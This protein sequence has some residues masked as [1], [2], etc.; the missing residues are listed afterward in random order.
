M[1]ILYLGNNWLGWQILKWLA[2]QG[3]HVVGLVIHAPA[4]QKFVQ[5]ILAAASLPDDRVFC[6]SDLTCKD[7]LDQIESLQPDIGLSVLF[8]HILR[9]SF[10]QIMPLG[11]LN[12]HPGLLPYN[13]GANPNVW[14][15]VDGTPAG[16]T[17]HRIDEG[18]D[19]GDI[20][21][22]CRVPTKPTDTGQRLYRR[23]ELASIELFQKTWPI[24]R[25]GQATC[26]PQDRSLGTVHYLRDVEELDR[27]DL[28]CDYPARKL[29]DV[30]RARTFPPYRGA[31]FEFEGRRI[32][33]RLQLLEEDELEEGN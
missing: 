14:S 12:L 29:I 8:G 18:I 24:V 26:T 4:R 25:S 15:I 5:E 6:A 1:R 17:I 3:D 33:L 28:E 27:I 19:T 22:Q 30:I 16:V 20:V 23:L 2:E 7:T 9:P 10:L 11:C 31:F 21:A 32:Y 13:R